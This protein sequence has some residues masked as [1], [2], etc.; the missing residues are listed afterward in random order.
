MSNVYAYAP[1]AGGLTW[2]AKGT[3]AGTRAWTAAGTQAGA[4]RQV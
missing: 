4:H 3:T 1:I 2:A